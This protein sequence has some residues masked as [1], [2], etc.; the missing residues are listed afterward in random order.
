MITCRLRCRRRNP[1][2]EEGET[3]IGGEDDV[4]NKVGVAGEATALDAVELG[5]GVCKSE[6]EFQ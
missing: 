3:A 2:A 6:R 4:L 1:R 5:K